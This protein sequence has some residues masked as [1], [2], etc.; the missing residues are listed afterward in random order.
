MIKFFNILV[1]L[2]LLLASCKEESSYDKFQEVTSPKVMA[3]VRYEKLL[4]N[5]DTANIPSSI[6]QIVEKYPDFST[7]YFLRVINDA[8]KP[9][10]SFLN[11]YDL[12]RKSDLIQMLND[13]IPKLFGN[14]SREE[15]DYAD[16]FARLQKLFPT[17]QVPAVYTCF[18]EFGVG[19][20]ST[21]DQSMAVSLEMYL[22][23]GNKYYDTETWPIFIQRTMNRENMVPNL[24]K[25]YIRNSILPVFEPKT[26]L[27]NMIQ[28]GKEIYILNHLIPAEQDTLVYDYSPSQLAFCRTNEK[29]IWS[30][31]LAE[32]LVYSQ[33]NKKIQKYVNPSPNSPGMPSDAPGRISAFIGSRIIEAYMERHENLDIKRLINNMNA[34]QILEEARYKP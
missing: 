12:Y 15:K 28:Q 22:G 18:T 7:I 2:S 25:N 6:N 34:Q 3:W 33:D 19:A 10:T 1:L 16:C 31:F 11:I 30:Y 9:D 17:V 21:S 8:Y 32:K 4:S 29:E 27:D 23:K 13:T 14:L 5:I 26:L 20:F 24:M